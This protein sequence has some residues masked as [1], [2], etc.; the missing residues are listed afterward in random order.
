MYL[1]PQMKKRLKCLFIDTS[2]LYMFQV[3]LRK[4]KKQVG[5][6]RGIGVPKNDEKHV[7]QTQQMP[8]LS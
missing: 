8:Q 6:K 7:H 1:R 5:K 2:I 4:I 3:S